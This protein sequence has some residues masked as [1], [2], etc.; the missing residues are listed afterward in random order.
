LKDEDVSKYRSE[1]IEKSINIE[2]ILNA[3]IS[4]HYLGR[5]QYNFIYEILYDEYCSFALKR[6]ILEKIIPNIESRKV[7]AL[8]RLNSI[9]NIFAHC[10]QK[11]IGGADPS[12]DGVVLD[13]KSKEIDFGKLYQE[14]AKLESEVNKYLISILKD[15]GAVIVN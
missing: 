15:K 2:W 4:Q 1:V 13:S 9:R 7:Q 5:V 3:I 10:N 14:F 12:A 6:R 11:F 8:N